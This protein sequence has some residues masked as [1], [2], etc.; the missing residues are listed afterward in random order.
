VETKVDTLE[1]P[2][3]LL[4]RQGR[5]SHLFAACCRQSAFAN[6]SQEPK[7]KPPPVKPENLPFNVCFP[8]VPADAKRP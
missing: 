1:R 4:D 5:P 6:S 2:F 3:I 7:A 8:L